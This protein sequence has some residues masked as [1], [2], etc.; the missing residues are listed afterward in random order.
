MRVDSGEFALKIE[1]EGVTVDL[2][3]HTIESQ[4][5][6]A[7]LVNAPCLSLFNGVLQSSH[8]ALAT[9]PRQQAHNSRFSQLE[10]TGDIHLPSDHLV[11]ESCRVRAQ[12]YGIHAGRSALISGCRIQGAILGVEVGPG[13]TVVASEISECEDGLYAL[14]A[15]EQS[16]T[17]ERVTV[18]NCRG[19]GL[20][21]DGPGRVLRCQV[22]GNGTELHSGGI[23]AGPASIVEECRAWDNLGGDIRTVDPTELRNNE[24]SDGT[25]QELSNAE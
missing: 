14:G 12:S 10:V 3:G 23:L 6:V 2:A 5:E 11:F 1:A 18:K 25:G 15:R 7:V 8:V 22:H 24:T 4:C 16:C 9:E 13:S 19:L 17:I 21:L 20:C